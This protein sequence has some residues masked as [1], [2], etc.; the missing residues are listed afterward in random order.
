[1]SSLLFL[2]AVLVGA[3]MLLFATT[4]LERL[5][6]LPSAPWSP[7]LDLDLV[8]LVVSGSGLIARPGVQTGNDH[9][10]SHHARRTTGKKEAPWASS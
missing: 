5:I 4:V 9:T 7:P 2:P 10:R 8:P 3:S 6:G 1:M